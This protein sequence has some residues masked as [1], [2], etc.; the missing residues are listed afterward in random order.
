[1]KKYR[2]AVLLGVLLLGVS[3]AGARADS[4]QAVWG[5]Y[6]ERYALGER[7][8]AVDFACAQGRPESILANCG[9]TVEIAIEFAQDEIGAA[10]LFDGLMG[11][12][13]SAARGGGKD[14][15]DLEKY[16]EV[17][18]GRV[19]P[20]VSQRVWWREEALDGV[21]TLHMPVMLVDENGDTIDHTVYLLAHSVEP[22]RTRLLLCADQDIVYDAL[23]GFGEVQAGDGDY[24]R[25]WLASRALVEGAGDTPA[26]EGMFLL[27]STVGEEGF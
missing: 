17:Y 2:A 11:V 8:W 6:E 18:G 1:M 4:L 24:L 3:G 15:A 13:L 7:L 26:L 23:M 27:D 9:Q 12:A 21:R 20:R 10:A 22:G 25:Q 14:A 5:R 19:S 16:D